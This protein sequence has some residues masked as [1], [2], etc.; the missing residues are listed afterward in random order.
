MLWIIL[1]YLEFDAV[2]PE[3]SIVGNAIVSIVSNLVIVL[4][5]TAL[6]TFVKF[7]VQPDLN[8]K[9]FSVFIL[10]FGG[11]FGLRLTHFLLA[12][13]GE[14]DLILQVKSL[15]DVLNALVL[16]FLLLFTHNDLQ[17]LLKED[18]SEKQRKQVNYVYYSILAS[19]LGSA[20][21]LAVVSISGN[22]LLFSFIYILLTGTYS[23]MINA[24]LTDPRV[25]FILPEKTYL[26][27]L[28]N[29]Y[30]ILKYSK[31]FS[32][33]EYEAGTIIIS[34]ALKAV[35]SLVSEFYQTEVHP[36]LIK[37]EENLI[38]LKSDQDFFIAVFSERDSKL[39]RNA[40]ENTLK[41][42]HNRFGSEL[43]QKMTDPE[44]M[45][46]DD[47]FEKTFYFIYR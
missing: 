15:S 10:L 40:M 36:E 1:T 21:I 41:E 19:G 2:S 31:S 17:L 22:F 12:L 32:K 11:I 30:G 45:D 42:L 25:A 5:F 35:S 4:G 37:F 6:A 16:V 33:E 9:Q 24:Y 29:S 47:I 28:V 14:M 8:Y 44:A 38:L 27:I 7:L 34:G 43:S 39:I 46:L 3:K 20:L 18:L 26:V 23:L 13:D